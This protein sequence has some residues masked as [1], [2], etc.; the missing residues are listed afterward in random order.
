MVG[1]GLD[2]LQAGNHPNGLRNNPAIWESL[3]VMEV[4]A[5]HPRAGKLDYCWADSLFPKKTQHVTF[6]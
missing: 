2:K 4:Q 1:D 5:F 6:C 3:S